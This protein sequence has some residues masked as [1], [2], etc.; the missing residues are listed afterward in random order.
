[1]QCIWL[2]APPPVLQLREEVARRE[3]RVSARERGLGVQ[4]AR[5]RRVQR[6][7][8]RLRRAVQKGPRGGGQERGAAGARPGLGG[9]GDAGDGGRGGARE[10]G[11]RQRR[12]RRHAV[13]AGDARAQ[14]LVARAVLV[15]RRLGRA[16]GGDVQEQ[17]LTVLL[18]RARRARGGC[19]FALRGCRAGA[20]VAGRARVGVALGRRLVDG[21]CHLRFLR[22]AGAGGGGTL[23]TRGVCLLWW[24]LRGVVDV[25]R[26]VSPAGAARVRLDGR[27]QPQLLELLLRVGVVGGLLRRPARVV[28]VPAG[29]QRH[30][31]AARR[32][33]ACAE[34]GRRASSGR[35]AGLLCGRGSLGR[36]VRRRGGGRRRV[37]RR[38]RRRRGI[39]VAPRAL[40]GRDGRARGRGQPQESRCVRG[41][42]GAM[43]FG[44]FFCF[45]A[46]LRL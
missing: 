35:R 32:V 30:G 27:R 41:R 20:A 5:P 9:R 42:L 1:V 36:K 46:Q 31:R 8:W 10:A 13:H 24:W 29:Y 4:L 6:R 19:I 26:V 28:G 38:G 40:R 7:A 18:I 16:V 14:L 34:R 33:M 3:V 2:R 23:V 25:L 12:G 22:G 11:R 37:R 15:A 43:M 39:G 44:G 21:A 17:V 45:F